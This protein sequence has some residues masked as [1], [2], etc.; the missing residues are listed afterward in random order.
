MCDETG[1]VWLTAINGQANKSTGGIA[2]ELYQFCNKGTFIDL[3][4]KFFKGLFNKFR[5][6][7]RSQEQNLQL[8][9]K[10]EVCCAQCRDL[11][12]ARNFKT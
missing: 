11:G 3:K 4:R 10:E 9:E 1:S 5:F 12:T 7:M 8:Y 6:T 2:S